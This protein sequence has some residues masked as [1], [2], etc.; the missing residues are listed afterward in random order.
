MKRSAFFIVL[1]MVF[2]EWLDFSLYLYLAK[3]VFAAEFFPVSTHSLMLTFALFAAA[4]LARPLGGWL[5]GREA[6]KNGRRKPMVFSAALM[7]LATLGICLLPGYAKW[8]VAATWCLLVLRL[9]QGLALGGEVNTSAMFLVEH[10]P[11]KPL[12]AGSLVAASG[13]AG[14]FTGGALAAF[15]QFTD[16]SWMWRIVFALVG[17]LS[18]WVCRLRKQLSESPEFKKMYSAKIERVWRLHWRGLLNIAAL[19]A[20]VSVTVYLCNVFWLSFAMEQQVWDK[21][22]CAWI[23]SFAQLS[24]ALLALPIAFLTKPARARQLLRGSMILLACVAPVLFFATAQIIKPLILVSLMGYVIVN[25]LICS[26]MYYFLYQ[27]L[28][29]EYRCWGVSTI[30]AMAASIGAASLPFAEHMVSKAEIYWLPGV[31]V[32][33]VALTAFFVL[34]LNK[35]LEPRSFL[36]QAV[37]SR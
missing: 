24:S 19:G 34:R 13:A 27:Q 5:F 4:Y 9:L 28:P 33:F 10:T 14:M 15:I 25:G 26:A 3:A 17:V 11:Q 32:S 8:G 2:L 18:L 20:F 6:D 22:T 7:G 29:A 16:V 23:G 21:V 30:W 31:L 37:Q 12:Y 1:A 35:G 36:P